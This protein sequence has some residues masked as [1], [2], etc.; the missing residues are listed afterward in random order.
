MTMKK[1]MDM[2]LPQTIQKLLPAYAVLVFYL[3]VI[4][5]QEQWDIYMIKRMGLAMV[6]Q[7][8]LF[9]L[10]IFGKR[11]VKLMSSGYPLDLYSRNLF[12]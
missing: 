7:W 3:V 5:V 9:Y 1:Y 8:V 6:S 10:C 12:V 11:M 2:I 4:M